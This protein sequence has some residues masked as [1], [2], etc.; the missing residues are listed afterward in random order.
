MEEQGESRE[1]LNAVAIEGKII[2]AGGVGT[3]SSPKST[4]NIFDVVT[5]T[6]KGDEE[7]EDIMLQNPEGA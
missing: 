3:T 6:F 7:K 5:G 1:D 2:F 4:V